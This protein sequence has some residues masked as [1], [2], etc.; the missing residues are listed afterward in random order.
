M[1]YPDVTSRR[2]VDWPALQ[3]ELR[4]A[5]EDL[6]AVTRQSCCTYLSFEERS[7]LDAKRAE[8]HEAYAG[9]HQ[10]ARE[11]VHL[12]VQSIAMGVQGEILL[13]GWLAS[14]KSCYGVAYNTQ[15]SKPDPSCEL[16]SLSSCNKAELRAGTVDERLAHLL[17]VEATLELN[18]QMHLLHDVVISAPSYVRLTEI[19]RLV[20]A[21]SR[22]SIPGS[23]SILSI[24]LIV[25]DLRSL[26]QINLHPTSHLLPPNAR[27]LRTVLQIYLNA[28][29]PTSR[30]LGRVESWPEIYP[31][32]IE[33]ANV[34]NLPLT[35]GVT[36][37]QALAGTGKTTSVRALFKKNSKQFDCRK[38]YL[39]FNAA[40]AEAAC[41]SMMWPNCGWKDVRV[42][43][44]NAL[45]KQME[46]DGNA[47]AEAKFNDG[48]ELSPVK[49]ARLL[50]LQSG[51]YPIEQPKEA[52]K[53]KGNVS[54][55]A[56]GNRVLKT[57]NKYMG[58]ADDDFQLCESCYRVLP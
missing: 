29:K 12:P 43:T 18:A 51:L 42:K 27:T 14:L 32:T 41:A 30:R 22:L 25:L 33:Q 40:M 37:V 34:A 36:I 15:D 55:Q 54:E 49:V 5:R 24:A 11:L 10:Q 56:I 17:P 47:Q 48:E 7:N 2:S 31:S 38:V 46:V 44:M 6:Q 3:E 57:L 20:Q 23:R 9:L 16:I 45:C 19:V 35:P 4:Q 50:D 58:S 28:T 39:V 26:E 13:C 52:G 8:L 21:G 1:V 53:R